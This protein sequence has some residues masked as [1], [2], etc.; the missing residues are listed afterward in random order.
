MVA[1]TWGSR[2]PLKYLI[3]MII[4]DNTHRAVIRHTFFTWRRFSGVIPLSL[5]FHEEQQP[6]RVTLLCLIFPG[7]TE[8][9]HTSPPFPRIDRKHTYDT[10]FSQEW[11]KAYIHHPFYQDWQKTYIRHPFSQDWQK[12]YIRH[13]LFPGLTQ[14]LKWK[15]CWKYGRANYVVYS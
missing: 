14:A 9:I 11:Q 8:N 6:N 1:Y 2:I 4:T 3:V 5:S 15:E 12:T 13:P 7:L 10:P